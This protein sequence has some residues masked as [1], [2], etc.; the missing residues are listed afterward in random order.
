ML[1]KAKIL[2]R[3]ISINNLMLWGIINII[4]GNRRG[5]LIDLD[6]ASDEDEDRKQRKKDPL[7]P[8]NLEPRMLA[9][10]AVTLKGDI[11]RGKRTVSTHSNTTSYSPYISD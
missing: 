1:F 6:Y 11:D 3:D 2:H 4:D 5:F 10:M 7:S 9:Q 8:K